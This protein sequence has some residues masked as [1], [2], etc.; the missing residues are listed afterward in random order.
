MSGKPICGYLSGYAELQ[1]MLDYQSPPNRSFKEPPFGIT[2]CKAGRHT[3]SVP[4]PA[5]IP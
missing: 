1:A 3:D 5:E 4:F 2:P